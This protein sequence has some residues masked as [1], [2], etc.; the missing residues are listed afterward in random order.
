MLGVHRPSFNK[1][2]KDMERDSLVRIGYS[3]IEV[4]DRNRLSELA[5]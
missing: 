4:I 2:L 5:R 1:V 3:E